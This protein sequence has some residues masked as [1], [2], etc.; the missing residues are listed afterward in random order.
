M[1]E[2]LWS[3]RRT[4]VERGWIRI[5]AKTGGEAIEKARSQ[6]FPGSEVSSIRWWA[7]LDREGEDDDE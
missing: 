1:T 7:T 4:I 3:V 2:R 5:R 6:G